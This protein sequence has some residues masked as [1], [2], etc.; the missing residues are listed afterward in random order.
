MAKAKRAKA[1]KAKRTKA[2]ETKVPRTP[3]LRQRFLE[4]PAKRKGSPFFAVRVPREVLRAFKAKAKAKKSTPND[5]VRE[6]MAEVGGVEL[7][8]IGG[9]E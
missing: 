7:P 9:E 8:E 3:I 5:L 1:K 4:P 6:F 2:T